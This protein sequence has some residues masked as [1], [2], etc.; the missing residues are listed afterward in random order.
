[1]QII[2]IIIIIIKCV[3]SRINYLVLSSEAEAE[4]NGRMPQA[5][6][7]LV[8]GWMER[9]NTRLKRWLGNAHQHTVPRI[10]CKLTTVL[11]HN[12]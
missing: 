4:T 7:S 9:F 6:I 8:L 10:K 2:T 11:L 12:A 5:S 1:M 3:N